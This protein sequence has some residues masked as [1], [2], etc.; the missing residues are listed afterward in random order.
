MIV[1]IKHDMQLNK[2]KEVKNLVKLTVKRTINI[3]G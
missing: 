3:P 2:S 1:T